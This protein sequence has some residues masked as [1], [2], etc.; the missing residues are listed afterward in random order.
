MIYH[1]TQVP[2]S[3]MVFKAQ[4]DTTQG[5]LNVTDIPLMEGVYCVFGG[6]LVEENA[7]CYRLFSARSTCGKGDELSF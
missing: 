1:F 7:Y 3:F 6:C 4:S 2:G 5:S